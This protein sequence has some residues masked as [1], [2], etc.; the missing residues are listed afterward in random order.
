MEKKKAFLMNVAYYGFF[1]AVIFLLWRYVVP[2]L[3][4]FILAFIIAAL[5]Q[6]PA[7]RLSKMVRCRKKWA[8]LALLILFYILI[9]LMICLGG[10]RIVSAAADFI[11]DL[12]HFYETR[13]VPLLDYVS[14]VIGNMLGGS[15]PSL[16]GHIQSGMEQSIQGLGDALSSATGS[17]LQFLSGLVT[18]I[19]SLIVRIVI[20]IVASFYWIYVLPI[21]Y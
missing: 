3:V 16:A 18:G 14:E 9:I 11:A 7:D 1:V 2:V 4:P 19:P 5:I 8:G 12:P 13:V 20:M 15:D 21:K 10:G 6:K 17:I